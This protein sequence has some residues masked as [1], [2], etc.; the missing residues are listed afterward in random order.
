MVLIG[1]GSAVWWTRYK[2]LDC[3]SFSHCV[4]SSIQYAPPGS[5][6]NKDASPSEPGRH[7]GHQISSMINNI[8]PPMEQ[9]EK[10]RI[11]SVAR[12]A[13]DKVAELSEA[14]LDTVLTTVEV[15]KAKLAEHRAE[16]DRQQ[17]LLD[18]LQSRQD[19]RK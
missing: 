10:E 2:S 15:L 19:D 6:Q 5:P 12:Q 7:A 14:T 4:R 8:P 11:A 1:A 3:H 13:G 18:R 17:E 16:R 9:R